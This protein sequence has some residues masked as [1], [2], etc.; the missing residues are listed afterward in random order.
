MKANEHFLLR[1]A[2]KEDMQLYLDWANDPTVRSNAFHQESITEETHREWFDYKLSHANTFMF[3]LERAESGEP[4][5]QIRFDLS[6]DNV[7]EID[8]SIDQ[9]FRGQGFGSMILEQ[10]VRKLQKTLFRQ[11][12]FSG[13]D[14]IVRG[15]VKSENIASCKAF[16]H[17]GFRE[18]KSE[19]M[20]GKGVLR[21]FTQMVR[22]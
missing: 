6:G 11:N 15:V 18:E 16:L 8:F 20:T 9:K 19:D 21:H 2:R 3:V 4:I 17:A 10:G 7:F 13:A 14:I 5:G 22:T 1:P 12:R